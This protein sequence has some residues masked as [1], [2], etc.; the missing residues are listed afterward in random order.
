MGTLWKV[1]KIK[2]KMKSSSKYVIIS[3]EFSYNLLNYEHN[4]YVCDFLNTIYSVWLQPCINEPSRFIR[5]QESTL[6]DH[7]FVNTL[8]K[9]LNSGNFL[10]KMSDHLPNFVIFKNVSKKITNCNIKVRDIANFNKI[11]LNIWNWKT[12]IFRTVLM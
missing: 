9:E 3:G 4:E 6:I 10:E 12:Y 8:N 2:C 11:F 1:W 5:K 7:I